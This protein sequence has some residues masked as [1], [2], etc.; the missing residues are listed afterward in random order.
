M[1]G[2]SAVPAYTSDSSAMRLISDSS[3]YISGIQGLRS[4]DGHLQ[5]RGREGILKCH[6]LDLEVRVKSSSVD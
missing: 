1:C 5:R 3:R 4:C 6:K 2:C